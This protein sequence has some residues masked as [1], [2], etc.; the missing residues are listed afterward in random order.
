MFAFF[1]PG[2]FDMLLLVGVCA[3]I[4]L[5]LFLATE[6]RTP[7]A[8]GGGPII[9][10]CRNCGKP[11]DAQAIACMSCG[12]APSNGNRF[13]H[14]CGS[15]TDPAAIVCVKCGVS[16]ISRGLGS[17]N[18]NLV[19]QHGPGKSALVALLLAFFFGP[20]GMFYTTVFGAIVMLAVTFIV[21]TIGVFT[22]GLGF[23]LFFITQPICCIWAVVAAGNSE[24]A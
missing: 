6:K 7:A 4:V 20:L 23:L 5:V 11:V 16:T 1:A 15:T 12:R 10:Y 19:Q 21:L 2:P 24:A 22:A 14:N 17:K 9:H 13:C 3:V 8:S 18:M